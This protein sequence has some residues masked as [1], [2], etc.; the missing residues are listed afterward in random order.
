MV[1]SSEKFLID[2]NTLMTAS[3]F[4]YAYDLVPSFWETFEDEIKAGNIVLLD[5]VKAEIDKGEDELKQWYLKEKMILKSVIMLIRKS[6]LN[7]RK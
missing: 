4:F 7:L 1:N 6:S 5:M 2:A 3:R